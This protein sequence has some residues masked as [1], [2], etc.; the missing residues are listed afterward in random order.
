MSAFDPKRTLSK[1]PPRWAAFLSSSPQCLVSVTV[2]IAVIIAAS[3]TI[4]IT[5]RVAVIIA[6]SVTVRITI[7]IVVTMRY[8]GKLFGRHAQELSLFQFQELIV[9]LVLDEHFPID[10][11]ILDLIAGQMGRFIQDPL[12]ILVD[13]VAEE[14][15]PSH[16]DVLR[17]QVELI[18]EA[19]DHV[20]VIPI[21]NLVALEVIDFQIRGLAI[22][23]GRYAQLFG[24]L[25]V[26]ELLAELILVPVVVT[27]FRFRTKRQFWSYCGLGVV[28]R[29]RTGLRWPTEVGSKRVFR[30]HE[31]SLASTITV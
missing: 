3:V 11:L 14:F 26:E 9:K 23:L 1:I 29:S 16:Q 21:L 24:L 8:N 20:N 4:R 18:L 31:D 17:L 28:T 22:L 5:V 6:A 7:F 15:R 13:R 10:L 25:D 30:K 27:P 12:A 2:R 19:D